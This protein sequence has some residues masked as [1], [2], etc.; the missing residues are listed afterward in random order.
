MGFFMQNSKR[1]VLPAW[2]VTAIIIVLV[3]LIAVFPQ[4]FSRTLSLGTDYN[5]H[6]NR[7][8]DAAMQIKTHK[9]SYMQSNFGF[10]QSGR[11]I[12]SVYGPFCAYI[13]GAL[14]L[15][16][17]TWFRFQLASAFI[18]YVIAASGMYLL[19]R[20]AGINRNY[21]RF[22]AA[23]II[24]CSW[25][26]MW[27]LNQS[28]AGVGMAF[29]PFALAAGVR[30]LRNR[31]LDAKGTLLLAVAVAALIQVHILS[32]F[33]AVVAL[34]PFVIV[35]FVQT[36]ARG[37]FSAHVLTAVVVA[38]LLTVN[39][40]AAFINVFRDNNILSTFGVKFLIAN[41]TSLSFAESYQSL[42]GLVFTLS[43]C[44]VITWALI[45]SH[46]DMV[47]RVAALTGGAF[48]LLSSKI[49]PWDVLNQYMPKL[50]HFLQFPD[51]LLAVAIPLLLVAVLLA[52]QE[53]AWMHTFKNTVHGT[54]ITRSVELVLVILFAF[55]PLTLMT[56]KG[57]DW[58]NGTGVTNNA[59]YAATHIRTTT[60]FNAGDVR[61]AFGSTDLAA[62]LRNYYTGVIDYLP[63]D[64]K[65]YANQNITGQTVYSELSQ[66]YID[67]IALP[68]RSGAFSKTVGNDGA[69][70]ISFNSKKAGN[71]RL[72]VVMYSNSR[73]MLNGKKLTDKDYKQNRINAPSVRVTKGKN[74]A[75]LQYVEPAYLKISIWVSLVAW[76][77]TIIWSLYVG[78]RRSELGGRHSVE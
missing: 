70:I 57:V 3:S 23:I 43:F 45:A 34:V 49:F 15:L 5:F 36:K 13:L 24:F 17:K 46:M 22:A 76:L 59:D 62:N 20:S 4:L 75:Q 33:L 40:W 42:L 39:Y 54:E 64:A 52:V 8:Y 19:A 68:S 50:K 58:M 37:R 27:A 71:V 14:L 66:K 18:L 47:Q 31:G 9:F 2:A 61:A 53:S 74:V 12:N 60:S 21:S 10:S 32:A 41:T 7:I 29:I 11:V 25:I 1:R 77:L 69:L 28:F 48:L 26:P 67:E 63:I 6:F 35:T 16:C 55:Q 78:L 44:F 30:M 65:D 72:P 38:V 56:Q 73:L 51:R